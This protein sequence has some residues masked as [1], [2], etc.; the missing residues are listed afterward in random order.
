V[1]IEGTNLDG[2]DIRKGVLLPLGEKGAARERMASAG[3]NTMVQGDAM[4]IT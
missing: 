1:W 2:K 4:L 3:V